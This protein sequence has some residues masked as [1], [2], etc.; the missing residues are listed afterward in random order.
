MSYLSLIS[1]DNL[2]QAWG[3]FRKGKS[4]KKDVQV[5]E[6][7]L[8]DNIFKLHNQLATR[9]YRHGTYQ[10]FYVN[11]P[12]TRHIHKAG[13]ADRIVHHLLYK[14]LYDIFD[15]VFIFDSY[16]CRIDKGTHRAVS[17]LGEFTRIVSKNYTQDCW[18]LKCDIK[19]FFASIDHD[20]LF[21]LIL[22]RVKDKDILWLIK[23]VIIS[24]SSSEVEKFP[25]ANEVLDVTRT[26]HLRP[27]GI[28]LG[29]LTSQIF[30]NI[31]LSELDRF[32]KHKLKI[33]YYLRYA[34][35]FLF[36][37][38]GREVL[39][40]CIDTLIQF[41]DKNLKLELHPKKMIFRKLSWGIDFCGCIVLPYYQLPRTKTKKR[42]FKKVS[43]SEISNKSLQSY[44]GHFSHANAYRLTQ[45]LKNQV[46]FLR[47]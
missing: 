32:I 47:T 13:V 23:R 43:M 34:D 5:F 24:Y 33:K 3:E 30:A 16:S 37:D 27:K 46:W 29:N 15:K 35:D 2:F 28:P 8:E 12:K 40:Q 21:S 44:L 25:E 7:Y 1:I 39:Y 6:R 4:R 19:K 9:N 31:Y 36:L 41:L 42:I 20:I 45:S 26:I 22:K 38:S 17:R 14:Y 11:D 18:A 10:E